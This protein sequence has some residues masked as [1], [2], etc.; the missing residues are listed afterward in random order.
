MSPGGKGGTRPRHSGDPR[1]SAASRLRAC[2][3]PWILTALLP[4]CTRVIAWPSV[5]PDPDFVRRHIASMETKPFDGVVLQALIPGPDGAAG[6]FTWSV[7][8]RRYT[9]EEFHPFVDLVRQVPFRRFRYNFLRINLNATDRP[10]DMFDDDRWDILIA[11]FAMAARAAREAGLGG[12]MVDP[13]AY[14]EEESGTEIPRFNVFDFRL[15][16]MAE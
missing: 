10:L 6:S 16:G 14:T 12:L 3:F 4:A 15:R 13:E 1:I 11:N 8:E 9:D 5:E 7:L 2:I